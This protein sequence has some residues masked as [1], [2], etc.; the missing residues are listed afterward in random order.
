MTLRRYRADC[1]IHTCL[2]PCAELTMAPRAVVARAVEL[3]LDIIAVTDHNAT[4]NTAATARAAAGTG[5]AVLPGIEVTSEEEVHVLGLFAARAD[6][7]ALQKAIYA[8]LPDLRGK[9]SFD[10]DQVIVDEDDIVQ[11]FNARGLF[12]AT[13]IPARGVVDL[14][15]AHGG[16]AVAC[17]IDREAFGVISQLGFIPP[18]IAFDAAEISARLTLAEGRAAF[19][20]LTGL[21]LLRS[22][23][24]HRPEEIG[25]G[26]TG[27]VLAAPTL[28]EIRKALRGEDGRRVDPS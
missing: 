20:G 4:E 14:I 25:V 26:E 9:R 2:S 28:A 7:R 22:S 19:A 1:H 16:L 12:G 10:E 21:P 8:E 6:L 3:G 17:H 18:D 24:A 11:G 27:F 15:H 13:R 23:D 5:L